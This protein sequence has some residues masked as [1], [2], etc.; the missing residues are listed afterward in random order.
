MRVG[1]D[2]ALRS[3]AENFGQAY[4]RHRTGGDNIGEDLAR[5]DRGQLIDIADEHKCGV[6]RQGTE[7]RPHQRHIDH[8]GLVDNEEVAVER[9]LLIASESTGLW[10][11]FEEPMDRLRLKPGALGEAFG[12]TT[13]RC[14]Q[15]DWGALRA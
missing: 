7:Y 12:G 11:G 3:L 9:R 6:I 13:R 4:D 14:A 15:S 10:I 2:S 1:D 8:R 5:P